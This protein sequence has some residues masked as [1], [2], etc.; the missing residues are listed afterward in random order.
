MR[1]RFGARAESGLPEHNR[2]ENIFDP[3]EEAS[4]ESF[5]ASDPPAWVPVHAGPPDPIAERLA[6]N[7]GDQV[8][9]NAALEEAA[10][11][12]EY[13][14]DTRP[15]GQLCAAIRAMKRVIAD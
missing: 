5:P 3:V 2:R 15:R 9:W 1:D 10:L 14:E 13:A 7:P 6:A 4:V 11:L 8:V 12:V